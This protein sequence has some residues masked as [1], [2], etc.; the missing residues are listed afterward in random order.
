MLR[1]VGR[2]V[3]NER[4]RV[5]CGEDEGCTYQMAVEVILRLDKVF[6]KSSIAFDRFMKSCRKTYLN[7]HCRDLKTD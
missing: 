4:V 2:R 1:E 6:I 7:N 3:D 5:N